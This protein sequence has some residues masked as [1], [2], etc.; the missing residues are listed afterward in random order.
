MAEVP[1]FIIDK[2]EI[3]KGEFLLNKGC[4]FIK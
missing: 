4:E 1:V 3:W 2:L